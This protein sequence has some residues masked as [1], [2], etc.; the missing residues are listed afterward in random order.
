MASG[1]RL[2]KVAAIVSCGRKGSAMGGPLNPKDRSS[3]HLVS[4]L[5]LFTLFVLSILI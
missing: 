5:M 1:F 4:Y 2:I 3:D